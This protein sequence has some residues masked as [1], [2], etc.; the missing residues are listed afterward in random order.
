MFLFALGGCSHMRATA[1]FIESVYNPDGF[2][3]TECD[4][5]LYYLLGYCDGN[6]NVTLGGD[7]TIDDAGDYYFKTNSESP[8]S[9]E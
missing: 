2:V 7:L 5:Y 4:S 8:Y 9:L 3:S 6:K 1:L